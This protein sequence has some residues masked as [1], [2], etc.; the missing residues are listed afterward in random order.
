MHFWG[1]RII[2]SLMLM[3]SFNMYSLA[4]LN[5][6]KDIVNE[7]RLSLSVCKKKV[8]SD[9]DGFPEVQNTTLQQ[10]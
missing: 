9:S 4:V 10:K 6:E 5:G 1:T 2:I 8:E 7:R 3:D